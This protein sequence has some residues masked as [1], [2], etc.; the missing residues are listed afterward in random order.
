MTWSEYLGSQ[1]KTFVWLAVG[2]MCCY[3]LNRMDYNARGVPGL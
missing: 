3:T 2:A 1:H